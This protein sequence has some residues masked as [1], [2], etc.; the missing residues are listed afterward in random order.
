MEMVCLCEWPPFCPFRVHP[1]G[2]VVL[3]ALLL[4]SPQLGARMIG[5]MFFVS[6]YHN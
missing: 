3:L 6:L 1:P 5:N 2:G 4:L